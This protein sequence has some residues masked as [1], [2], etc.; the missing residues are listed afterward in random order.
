MSSLPKTYKAASFEK[1]NGPF[2]LES[3]PLQPPQAGEVLIK[4]L[5]SG[6]CGSDI[7]VHT[8]AFHN[9]FPI[10][11]GHEIIG[12]V[13]AIGEG[14]TRWKLGD[15]VG[16]GWHGGHDFIC[17]QCQRG[18]Y[19]MCQ[20][21][22]VNGVT[23]TGGF[24]EYVSLRTEAVAKVPTDVDPV[25]FAPILCAGVTVFNSIRKL[26]I[27]AG[28]LVAIQGLGG[29]GHLAVQYANKLG[30]KVVV[31][32]SGGKKRDF[33]HKL[34]AHQYIDTSQE[35]PNKKL[36]ELGGAA[37]IVAT[38]PNPKIIGPLTGG[39]Q[40][41][42]RLL[43]LA[44]CGPIEVNSVDLIIKDIGVVGF[45]SGHALDIEET[46]NF[47]QL[48]DVKCMVETFP[49][50]DIQ[51]AFDYMESGQVRFRSVLVM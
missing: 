50:N 1:A 9:S 45:P 20:K 14:E 30:Y 25:E 23:R 17:K 38:A 48:H 2:V 5:A 47:T 19:Q 13:V 27:T 42:G 43:V 15:R 35:D 8:G 37:L 21:E 3:I 11:P 32:S 44:P 40:P 49:L 26:E 41:G 22:A 6:I 33:A 12:D 24:A 7:G 31:L 29:L 39:L 16:G 46:I 36:Q 51:K 10:V 4:V 34:G 28:E 18:Q